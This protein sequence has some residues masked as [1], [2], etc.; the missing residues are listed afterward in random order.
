MLNLL[1]LLRNPVFTALSL[2]DSVITDKHGDSTFTLV[3]DGQAFTVNKERAKAE[4]K[5]TLDADSILAINTVL[6][7]TSDARRAMAPDDPLKNRLFFGLDY[8][9]PRGV[10][11]RNLY[12]FGRR[13][14]RDVKHILPNATAAGI[15]PSN[16][17]PAKIRK[18]IA[19]LEWFRTGSVLKAA[20]KIGNT[21]NVTI[22]HYIPA[23]LL[24]A[25]NV[26]LAR[27]F[28]N[29]L[30]ITASAHEDYC[31]ASTDF[32]SETELKKFVD[33]MLDEHNPSSS[34]LASML[35]ERFRAPEH[36]DDTPPRSNANGPSS[37]V[38]GISAPTLSVLYAFRDLTY[39]R[40]FTEHRVEH[41]A[42]GQQHLSPQAMVDLAD[43]L[44]IRLPE[45]PDRTFRDA[46]D[47]A[48][49]IAPTLI[50]KMCDASFASLR[51]EA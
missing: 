13:D 42:Q 9:G 24:R 31:A 39:E 41:A 27:R 28:Q 32:A 49:L 12:S 40:G 22:K 34:K 50:N 5:S 3:T 14:T 36:F 46:H 35:H 18:T 4:K 51:A 21:T 48:Q 43:L 44:T 45:H 19:V 37:L 20:T 7:V 1:L 6:A 11:Y 29:L 33:D 2:Y 8:M 47:A 38:I 17:I 26:R 30:L 10:P 15:P 23:A 16:V 25:W